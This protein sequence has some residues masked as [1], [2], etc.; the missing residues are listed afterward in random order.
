[1][2][3]ISQEISEIDGRSPESVYEL[4]RTVFHTVKIPAFFRDNAV[5]DTNNVFSPSG[6]DPPRMEVRSSNFVSANYYT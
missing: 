6:L 4:L 2:E 3:A 5:F 1:M